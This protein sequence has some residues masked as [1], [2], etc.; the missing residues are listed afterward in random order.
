MPRLS[1]RLR[2]GWLR[3][4]PARVDLPS[5]TVPFQLGLFY[6]RS[7]LAPGTRWWDRRVGV[8]V[9]AIRPASL[10]RLEAG[11]SATHR[12]LL[13]GGS[14]YGS[15]LAAGASVTNMSLAALGGGAL[16]NLR[17][18][19]RGLSVRTWTRSGAATVGHI[20]SELRAAMR[21]RMAVDAPEQTRAPFG[22]GV[23]AV[24]MR[25]LFVEM[26]LKDIRAGVP[27]VFLNFFG[28]DRLSHHLGPAAPEV[29]DY[30]AA[31]DADIERL[32]RSAEQSGRPWNTALFSDHGQ[33]E[34][35]PFEVMYGMTVEELV[36][37]VLRATAVSEPKH[38]RPLVLCSGNLAH[39]YLSGP[40]ALRVEELEG[41]FPGLV[42]VLRRHQGIGLVAARAGDGGLWLGTPGHAASIPEGQPVPSKL[43]LGPNGPSIVN[44]VRPLLAQEDAGDLVLFGSEIDGK[45][46][47][48]L[49]QWGCHNG[50][51]GDQLDAFL[52]TSPDLHLQ[53]P[54]QG[55]PSA[56]HRQL[57]DLR[58]GGIEADAGTVSGDLVGAPN[59]SGSEIT[60]P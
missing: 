41:R 7:D 12:G 60:S 27:V 55:V 37:G 24:L 22:H 33:H 29:F 23:S 9:D 19:T 16:P 51:L 34:A 30:L 18:L 35:R 52:A 44:R 10:R 43:A 6:G 54:T 28:H 48:F 46:V 13:A 15:S 20:W 36:R 42:G 14:T 8:V 26:A 11:V 57:W 31:A 50:F 56:L 3:L 47:S 45:L 1:E 58:S 53:L 49:R 32:I 38:T 59:R 5:G 4:E 25:N 2:S 21:I 39:I 40:R 17:K